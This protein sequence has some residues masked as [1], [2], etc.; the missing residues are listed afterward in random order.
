MLE[1]VFTRIE[2][3]EARFIE[4]IRGIVDCTE[5]EARKVMNLYLKEKLAKLSIG[6]G[7]INVKHGA[8]LEPDVIRRAIIMTST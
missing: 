4:S 5:A 8:F 6:V 3:A 1:D 7:Q 2:N